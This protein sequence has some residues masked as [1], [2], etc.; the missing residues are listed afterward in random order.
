MGP[1][2][3]TP[4]DLRHTIGQAV[5]KCEVPETANSP[6][7]PRRPLLRQPSEPPAAGFVALMHGRSQ[8]TSPSC[9][10]D[11]ASA[12]WEEDDMTADSPLL[13]GLCES[14]ATPWRGCGAPQY[15]LHAI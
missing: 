8:Q 3:R 15:H 14:P 7:L 11:V 6:P 1:E 12:D 5:K 13:R 9:G 2:P 4:D 10:L